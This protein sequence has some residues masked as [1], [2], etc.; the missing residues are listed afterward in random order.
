MEKIKKISNNPYIVAASI[1]IV[2]AVVAVAIFFVNPTSAPTPVAIQTTIEDFQPVIL[3]PATNPSTDFVDPVTEQDHIK[4]NPNAPTK[5]VEYS[6]YEC[7]FCKRLHL[8]MNQLMDKYGASGEVAWVYRHFP[9]DQLHPIKARAVAVAAECSNEQGG[10]SAFWKF[11]DRYF[12]LAKSNNQ[13]DIGVV[14]PLIVNE[15]GLDKVAFDQCFVSGKYNKHIQENFDNAVA[16]GG[17]GTP[18]SV[19]IGPDGKTYPLNGAQTQATIE[20]LI[21]IAQKNESL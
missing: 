6:D 17:V 5:I 12:E 11:S 16:T 15:I 21:S 20:Q 8:T 3:K 9:I 10:N 1:L 19:L 18:W 14:I 13:T 2:A 4:G 7:P